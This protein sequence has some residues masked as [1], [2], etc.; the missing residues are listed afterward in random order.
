M[1]TIDVTSRGATLTL[2]SC[3]AC[4]RHRWARDGRPADRQALLDGVKTYLDQPRIPT[5]RKRRT[6]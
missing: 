3:T 6:G 2:S 4:G 5:P 1:S